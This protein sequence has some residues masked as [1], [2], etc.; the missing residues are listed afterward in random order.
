MANEKQIK[1]LMDNL[2]VTREEALEII[3]ADEKIDGGE[4]LFELTDEQKKNS[5]K[6]RQV[7]RGVATKPQKRE[8]KVDLIKQKILNGFRIY[9][10]GS[11]AEVEP[12][13]TE[14]EMHFTFDDAQYTVKLVKHRPP[15]K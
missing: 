3:E 14:A 10:E 6:A 1:N 5:K 12:L 8:R 7:A 2:G 11:G 13:K 9:L 4:K 15:K